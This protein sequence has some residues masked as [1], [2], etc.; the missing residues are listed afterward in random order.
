MKDTRIK[1]IES[2]LEKKKQE[3]VSLLPD[4]F[5]DDFNKNSF[6]GGGCI[7]SLYNNQKPKDYDFFVKDKGLALK[8]MSAF[9]FNSSL[10]YG[11]GVK[12]GMYKDKRLVVTD[13]AVSIGDF[14]IVTRWVGTPEEVIS[15]FDY[16]HNMFYYIDGKLGTLVNW[17]YLDDNILRFN[18]DRPRDICGCIIRSNKFV[19]RGFELT[20]VEMSKMLLKLNEVGFN[21]RELE[22]LKSFNKER[23][24]FGS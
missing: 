20:N 16:K 12:I 18:D 9:K 22:I 11:N 24:N 4:S 2:E 17:D 7:Y 5:K 19:E 15:E 21:E 23:N 13:N 6:I 14:Q 3:L 10:K 1:L 8:I